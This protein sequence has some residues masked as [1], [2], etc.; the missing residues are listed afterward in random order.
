MKSFLSTAVCVCLL[1]ASP[2]FALEK[3][4]IAPD[5]ADGVYAPEETVTWSI[6]SNGLPDADKTDFDYEVLAGG[7][8]SIQ[9]GK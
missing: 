3:I 5:K 1:L 7:I 6:G 8:R 2:I 9:K 4:S